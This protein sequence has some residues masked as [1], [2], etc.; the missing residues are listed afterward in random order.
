MEER[1][2]YCGCNERASAEALFEE[3]ASVIAEN[4]VATYQKEEG[5]SLTMRLP[6]GQQ[7]QITVQEKV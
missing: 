1:E 5:N 7:F 6:N 3:I 4:F 2:C